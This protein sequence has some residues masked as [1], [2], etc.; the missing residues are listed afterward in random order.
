MRKSD[1]NRRELLRMLGYAG[2]GG[3]VA[4]EQLAG[5]PGMATLTS[6][7]F[8]EFARV[9]KYDAYEMMGDYLRGGPSVFAVQ[10]AMAQS[11][12]DW[13]LVQIKVCNHVYTPLVFKLGKLANGTATLGSDVSL[14]SRIGESKTELT[15]LGLEQISEKPRFQALRFNKWFA[16]MLYNGTTNGAAPVTPNLAGLSTDDIAPLSDDKVAIQA[17]LGLKQIEANNHALKGC[18]M[19]SNLPDLTLFAQKSGVIQSPLGISCFMMGINYDKAEGALSS[20]AVLGEQSEETAVVSSR[21]VSAY[22]AQIQQFVG[23]GYADRSGIEQNITYRIDKLVDDNPVLRQDLINSIDQFNKGLSK[24]RVAADLETNRQTLNLATGNTQ[25][26]GVTGKGKQVGA[27]TAFLAQCKYVANSL[28]LPGVPVRNFSLF[29]NISDL[30][31]QPL[32]RGHD[33]GGTGDV[34]AFSYVE[35]MRQLA[36]GLNIL[37]KKIAEG[38]KIVVVV[39]SEG[40]RG[41]DMADNKT[42]FALVMGPKGAGFLDDALYSN[43][44]SI[45]NESNNIVKNMAAPGAAMAWDTDGMMEKNG[46][47]STQVPS[48]GDVQM[49]A[50]QFLEEKTGKNARAELSDSDGRYVM[51]K[52]FS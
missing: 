1:L 40:G 44:A 34:Q 2:V 19:R 49:G 10:Q 26:Q 31:G 43:Y 29:L 14:F 30:D 27:T 25:S 33:G 15:A 11:N 50:I 8:G 16:D 38:S 6:R 28:D 51:L 41:T 4:L 13:N 7:F 48:T 5:V 3:A 42:S 47:K 23:K 46:T 45:D 32:D 24:L 18:K 39:S 21:N 17:F 9:N 12:S 22:V 37:G 36:M 20:N 35:G 52:R